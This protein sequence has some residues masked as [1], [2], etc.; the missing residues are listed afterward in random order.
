[1]AAGIYKQLVEDPEFD[2]AIAVVTDLKQS[3]RNSLSSRKTTLANLRTM[4]QEVEESYDKSRKARIGSTVATT[5]RST[6]AVIG[7][8]LSF[9]TLGA[10]LGLS[11]AGCVLAAAGGITVAGA[12]I[13]YYAVWKNTLEQ[14]QNSCDLD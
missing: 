9:V 10:S 11:I 13:R 7:F 2:D 1:M 4:K 14:A 5:T 6:L 3:L 12:E 8:G